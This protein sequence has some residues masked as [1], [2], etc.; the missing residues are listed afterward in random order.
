M[1]VGNMNLLRGICRSGC[2]LSDI[3]WPDDDL[4]QFFDGRAENSQAQSITVSSTPSPAGYSISGVPFWLTVFSSNNNATPDTLS[5]QIANANCGSCIA[6][7]RRK[8][9]P[10]QETDLGNTKAP[11]IRPAGSADLFCLFD[12]FDQLRHDLEQVADDAVIGDFEN[13][14]VGVLID[15][16]DR[17]RSLHADQVLNCAGDPDC[18]VQ[19]RRDGLAGTADLPFHL[20]PAGIAD[21]PRG[22]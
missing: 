3:E 18:Q 22:G 9:L 14:S 5:F 4:R 8:R 1:L 12:S 11:S 6:N 16:D 7:V 2:G 20:K 10:H 15:G 13:R 17:A 21:G 19:L